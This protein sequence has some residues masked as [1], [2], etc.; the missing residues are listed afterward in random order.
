[1]LDERSYGRRRHAARIARV[2]GHERET[3]HA[4]A[5]DDRVVLRQKRDVDDARM[6]KQV[7]GLDLHDPC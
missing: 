1:V 2:L 6:R 7:G 4:R 5:L 3:E